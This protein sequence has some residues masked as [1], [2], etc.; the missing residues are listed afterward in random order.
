MHEPHITPSRLAVERMNTDAA[1]S[2]ALQLLAEREQEVAELRLAL[3]P[4]VMTARGIPDNWP[5]ECHLRI[6]SEPVLMGDF[7]GCREWLCYH[8]VHDVQDACLPTIAQ[9]REAAR[10]AGGGND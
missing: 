3:K 2:R 4:F 7:T 1:L 8:G 6:D 5:G 10:A 9:W